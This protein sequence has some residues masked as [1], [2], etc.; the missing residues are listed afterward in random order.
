MCTS[1]A[2]LSMA[3]CQLYRRS[4]ICWRDS[5]RPRACSNTSSTENSRGDISTG[6]PSCITVRAAGS[7]SIFP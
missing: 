7:T 1:T 6:F 5:T 3:D 2:L 4:S